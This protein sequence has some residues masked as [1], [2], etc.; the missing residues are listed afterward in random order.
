MKEKNTTPTSRFRR[1]PLY[2]YNNITYVGVFLAMLIFI[3]ECFLFGIDFFSD[4]PNIYLGIF[5]YVMLPMILIPSLILIPWGALRK[6]RRVQKGLTD[7]QPHPF[8][9]DLGKSSHRNLVLVLVPGVMILFVMTGIGSYKAFQ[10]T[11]SVHFCGV[12][13]HKVMKPE[14]TAYLNSPHARVKCVECHIGAGADWFVRSKLAGTRQV[15]ATI[16]NT[17]SRPIPTPIHNLR[18]ARETCEECHWPQKFYSAFELKREYFPTAEEGPKR[19]ELRMLVHEGKGEGGRKGLHAHMTEY[20]DIFYVGDA[21]RQQI[22]WVKSID[23]TGKETI[24]T[25]EDSAY[26]GKEPPAEL[27][28]KM[29]CLDCHNRP[30]HHY[31]SPRRLLES[32]MSQGSVAASLPNIKPQATALMVADYTTQEEAATAIREGLLSYY[33]ENY[34]D[35]YASEKPAIDSSIDTIITLYKG[36]FFPVMKARWDA[37]PE[38]IGH[39]SS[40]GCFRCHDNT[41]TSPE[42]KAI[43]HD[44]K[45]CHTIIEQGPPDNLEK[46]TDGLEF[47]HPVN[48]DNA[49]KEMPC[50]TCHDQ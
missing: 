34:P 38:N 47:K 46:S 29:D 33:K 18:P 14:Y 16:S 49:W 4:A 1:F 19:W 2:F 50:S 8:H 37:Y 23:K 36:N 25:T 5:T 21:S 3:A 7:I 41:H 45:V 27:V 32:A 15:F 35:L 39:L 30:S 44:C 24:Y 28:R 12:V 48:I 10:Y 17:Y 31:E 11:E 26:R 22:E 9:L 13:C 43:T 20:E 6:Y 40:P 42:G